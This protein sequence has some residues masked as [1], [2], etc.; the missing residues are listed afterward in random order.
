[1]DRAA[2]VVLLLAA[3]ACSR[4]E[5]A[6]PAAQAP[7]PVAARPPAP[8]LPALPPTGPGSFALTEISAVAG[9][10]TRYLASVGDGASQ[11]CAFDIVIRPSVPVGGGHSMA[12]V[13][14]GR[15]PK[16]DCTAFLTALAPALGFKAKLP[17]PAAASRVEGVLA[18]LGR[19]QSA[20]PG[21]GYSSNP[22]GPWT[23]AKLFLADDSGEVYLNLDEHDRAGEFS[24][25]DEDYAK[26]VV[27]ELAKIMLP[28]RH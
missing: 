27:T 17:R 14:L 22:P 1:M 4:P 10:A 20:R 15:Q 13:T 18:V 26:I 25:K 11:A 7:P 28:A 9:G 16:S 21:G 12:D 8:P 2:I 23:A 5:P 3:S 6:P 19:G 24:I